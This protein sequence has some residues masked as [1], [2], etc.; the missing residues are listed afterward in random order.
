MRVLKFGGTSVKSPEVINK[1]I[2]IVKSRMKKEKVVVVVSAFGGVTD[3]LLNLSRV[4]AS[5]DR[6]YRND[7]EKLELRHLQAVRDLVKVADQSRVLA[8]TKVM[9]NALDDVLHGIYL[10]RE[11][12][13]K[14]QDFILSFGERLSSYI[15]SEAL[16]NAGVNA[17][18]A[19]ATSLIRTA[20]DYGNATVDFN[21][22]NRLIRKHFKNEK[23][24]QVVPGF[25]ASTK[26][27]HIS[28]LGRGGSDYTAAI[29]AAALKVSELEIWTDVD[30]IMTADPRKVAKAF[31]VP[32]LSYEETMELSHFGAKVVYPPSI[33]PV[34]D[35][36]IP[37]RI[38]N[39]FNPDVPGTL[40][41]KETSST[42][43][44]IKG[45]SS[46]DDVSLLTLHGSGMIGVA[47]VSMR[48]FGA[49]ARH[50]VSVIMISQ[51]S[52]EHSINFAVRPSDTATACEAIEEEFRNEMTLGHI[53]AVRVEEGMSIVAV[54]GENMRR[55]PGV[56][57]KLFS[58]LGRNGINI[59]AIAQ[60]S[61]ELNIS[62]AVGKRDISKALNVIHEGFFLSHMKTL[63]LFIVG[64]GTVGGTLLEQIR[65]QSAYLLENHHLELRVVGLTNTR[66]MIFDKEGVALGEWSEVLS[67][68]GKKADF[69]KFMERMYACN[70]RNS[71]L[72]D[73]TSNET[74]A[75]VYEQ[76]LDQ[77]I[78]VVTPNKIACSSAYAKYKALKR[79]AALRGARF[80][81]ETNVGAGLPVVSTLN[82]LIR[83]GDK[84]HKIEAVLSGTLNYLFNTV[85]PKSSLSKT[86]KVA[87]EMGYAEPDPRIDLY[88]TDVARKILILARESGAELEVKDVKVDHFL[89]AQVRKAK[90]VDGF[91]K[92][93][94]GYDKEFEE[95]RSAL[96]KRK[97]KWRYV[98]TYEKGKAVLAL[99]EY[100]SD[101]PF[102][103]IDGSDNIVLFTTSRYAS[104]PLVVKGAGA[105]AAVTA[106]GVLA[107][108]VR[109]SV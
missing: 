84:I 37:F 2:G 75:S 58:S 38:L 88:G 56:A 49:L 108:I 93:L 18:C 20:N 92:E 21:T 1:V 59:H 39:T 62:L 54:V 102:Y 100:T 86:V 34:M 12:S 24:L 25:I 80:L 77:S 35:L 78:S 51:A 67:K 96:E 29:L 106:A 16:K 98:A 7:L 22:T 31:P 28:T 57:G 3:E 9:L 52:S 40:V 79:T 26:D 36:G 15:I 60:G 14:T 69:Q 30:G 94:E 71:V 11:L 103:H 13:I 5:G 68:N 33:Q 97:C 73:C 85:G 64:T 104:Q 81:F 95:K 83:S 19:D 65:S 46:I 63:N 61:F 48:L 66:K 89:P 99:K 10:V 105:G 6:S 44:G 17:A 50:K 55:I 47:G 27:G 23:S 8:N 43:V 4:A 91:F 32:R 90:D 87:R 70:L 101:H 76:A 45:I 107:D 41:S 53:E 72:V 42:E 82:D 74:V 109:V